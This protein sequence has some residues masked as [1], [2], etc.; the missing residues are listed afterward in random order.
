M[1]TDKF[2]YRKVVT[3]KIDGPVDEEIAGGGAER[4][5]DAV[6]AKLGELRHE[7]QGLEER[8]L[9]KAVGLL[10]A[11]SNFS[12]DKLLLSPLLNCLQCLAKCCQT[13]GQKDIKTSTGC[14]KGAGSLFLCLRATGKKNQ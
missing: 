6:E 8:T 2:G 1:A 7:L 10:S 5:D 13:I 4:Q 11:Y 14:Q 12:S 9:K 3:E